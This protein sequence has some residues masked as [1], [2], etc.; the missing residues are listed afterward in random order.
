VL[1]GLPK[2]CGH[3]LDVRPFFAQYRTISRSL[4]SLR[5]AAATVVHSRFVRDVALA[6]GLSGDSL[7]VL[8]YYVMRNER[9][10]PRSERRTLL[11]AGRV[12]PEKGLDLLVEALTLASGSW[13]ELVVAGDGWDLERCRR[14]AGRRGI[15]TKITFLGHRST[16]DVRAAMRR[17]RMVVVPS[18]WP[19]PF[20]IVGLEAMAE[21]RPVVGSNI[22]GIPEWLDGGETGLLVEPGDAYALADAIQ[23]LL[24]APER[25]DAMGQEGWRRVERFSPD[26]H[27]DALV[28]LY[29]RV[30][31]Q[32]PARVRAL[33]E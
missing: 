18:R 27:L 11:F 5:H 6:N 28:S 17:S 16:A 23:E 31:D 25:A 3:R 22:G 21:A 32:R 8:P 26:A 14:L 12:V 10:A 4:P 29:E 19:E 1:R 30:A 15:E 24:D 20:G 13:E 7:V 33:A 9:P 2:G